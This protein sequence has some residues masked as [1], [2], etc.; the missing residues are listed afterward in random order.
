MPQVASKASVLKPQHSGP[1]QREHMGERMGESKDSTSPFSVLLADTDSMATPARP[2]ANRP[3][4]TV[5][6]QRSEAPRSNMQRTDAKRPP[7]S[8]AAPACDA[9]EPASV[10][11]SAEQDDSQAAKPFE[12]A[13]VGEAP[14]PPAPTDGT[15]VLTED[16]TA[17]TVA[18]SGAPIE[19]P[20]PAQPV[21][22]A[23]PIPA[24]AVS[25]AATA[26]VPVATTPTDSDAIESAAA[27][28]TAATA[29]ADE[30]AAVP[31]AA[32]P[33][34]AAEPQ[35]PS[36]ETSA[37]QAAQA[38]E[39]A[40]QPTVP[41]PV[42]PKAKAETKAAVDQTGDSKTASQSTKEPQPSTMADTATPPAGPAHAD[43]SASEKPAHA[44][45]RTPS[46]PSPRPHG[47]ATDER[48]QTAS[49]VSDF[50]H[51]A[52]Q[53]TL[54]GSQLAHLQTGR[55]LG[56]AVAATAHAT[57]GP[58]AANVVV[59]APMPLTSVAVEIA[60]RAQGGNNRFEIRLDPPELGRIDVRLDIDRNGNVTSRL[61]VE[62]AET[63]DVLRRDA[64]QLERALQD[65]GLKTS[66]NGLQFSLRDQSFTGRDD[67]GPS[68]GN[69][70]LIADPE[71]P[72]ATTAPIAYGLTLRGGSGI[73]IRV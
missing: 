31:P 27:A 29:A 71:T 41:P 69:R 52:Q 62:K 66:D 34:G 56:H 58:D 49:A 2:Q 30:A 12:T 11:E 43:K 50:V 17:T 63:L 20:P 14:V 57:Q 72:A 18:A 15:E 8:D 47:A 42:V 28:G 73:D 4:G 3:N 46:P 65:A 7:A 67:R 6:T 36:P 26:A 70:T 25:D 33:A 48:P 22:P 51:A 5:A 9:T 68:G 55:D 32:A 54:D 35:T 1:T 61:V 23:A 13:A 44:E 10:T 37:S 39:Q 21:V 64:H 38:S 53:P 59:T 16:Q 19:M 40:A 60:A 24:P 45:A